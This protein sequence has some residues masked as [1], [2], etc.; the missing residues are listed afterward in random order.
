MTSHLA[1]IEND[2]IVDAI[3]SLRSGSFYRVKKYFIK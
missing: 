3:M 2:L 1:A